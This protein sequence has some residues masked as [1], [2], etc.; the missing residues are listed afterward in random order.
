M[1]P[2]TDY[3][4]IV[5]ILFSFWRGWNKGLAE[6]ML[7][8]LSFVAAVGGGFWYYKQSGDVLWSLAIA[9]VGPVILRIIVWVLQ[10]LSG[11]AAKKYEKK[12]PPSAL[13]SIIASCLNMVWGTSLFLG[14]LII[15]TL[16]P[17][18]NHY[19]QAAQKDIKYSQTYALMQDLSNKRLPEKP[20]SDEKVK[21]W[22]KPINADRWGH[23]E[24]IDKNK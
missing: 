23:V 6:M 15:V 18:K 7:G 3:A 22:T 17:M 24:K 10:L 2:I 19:I 5:V 13:T 1:G 4:L 12:D 20:V 21:E 14:F 9:I 11:S 8:P 16:L